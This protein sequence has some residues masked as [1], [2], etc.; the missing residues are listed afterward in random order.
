MIKRLVCD[1]FIIGSG[2]APLAFLDTLLTELPNK[3]LIVVDK[4][5]RPGGQ[6]VDAYDFV[7]LHQPSIVYGITS[8]ALEGNW[9]K[10]LF[11]KFMLPWQHRASK[12]ELLTYFQEFV[13]AKCQ[14]GQV[15]YFPEC[16]YDFDQELDMKS[17]TFTSLDGQQSYSV[18]IRE[19]L[20]NGVQ[21]ECIIPSLNPPAFPVDTGINLMTPNEIYAMQQLSRMPN[22]VKML[23]M[24]A[25]VRKGQWIVILLFLVRG[26]QPWTR[27]SFCKRLW[28]LRPL[29]FR[30]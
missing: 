30:G 25:W 8:K 2:A 11:T 6:W 18:E 9:A 28:G 13:T 14:S 27:W 12:E 29:T 3:K 5:A 4:K 7:H 19:K 16:V 23:K 26:K 10:L 15:E 1:Y 24:H 22:F 20:I 21:G 17:A